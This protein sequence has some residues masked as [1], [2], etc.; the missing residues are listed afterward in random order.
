MTRAS[1]CVTVRKDVSSIHALAMYHKPR[2]ADRY[3]LHWL[4]PLFPKI[5]WD[6]ADLDYPLKFETLQDVMGA[7]DIPNVENFAVEYA[8]HIRHP[9]M[10]PINMKLRLTPEEERKVQEGVPCVM[11]TVPI[12]WGTAICPECQ[13]LQPKHVPAVAGSDADASA[14]NPASNPAT[15]DQDTGTSDADAS[16]G[17]DQIEQL[18][19][20]ALKNIG[21]VQKIV[22]VPRGYE[23][24]GHRGVR[25]KNY[26]QNI[27]ERPYCKQ[28]ENSA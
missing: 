25:P 19:A 10:Y 12:L 11:C 20:K 4:S 7:W 14:S 28:T 18:R 17:A 15:G 1:G 27:L 6:E 26:L 9:A 16:A 2:N 22:V 8:D 3:Q 23:E 13:S 24:R 5:V 21:V